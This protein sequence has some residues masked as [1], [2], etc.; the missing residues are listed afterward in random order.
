MLLFSTLNIPGI[1]LPDEN[2]L[3]NFCKESSRNS[4]VTKGMHIPVA[5]RVD[6]KD[7]R[8]YIGWYGEYFIE[9]EDDKEVLFRYRDCLL[10]TVEYDSPS[11][12]FFNPEFEKNFP[13]IV[14]AIKKL[15]FKHLYTAVIGVADNSKPSPDH[16]DTHNQDNPFELDRVNIQLNSFVEQSFYLNYNGTKM[17][18]KVDNTYPCY[19]FNNKGC[20]HGAI[21]STNPVSRMILVTGGILDKEKYQKLLDESLEKF[22]DTVINV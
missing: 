10:E 9:S 5:C 18:P 14:A 7:W 1:E 12:L 13:T 8:G 17:H 21:V 3:Y 6:L 2:K 19:A 20:Q 11:T 16:H 15:P 4:D 22:K